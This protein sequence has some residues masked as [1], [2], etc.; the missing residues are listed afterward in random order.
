MSDDGE[1][2]EDGTEDVKSESDEDGGLTPSTPEIAARDPEWPVTGSGLLAETPY[3]TVG[4]DDVRR[5]DGEA[6]Y[7]W[8][9][10]GDAVVVVAHDRET[11]ELLMVEQYRPKLRGR[12]C[13]LPGG[14]IDADESPREAARRELREET[15]YRAGRLD[16]LGAYHPSSY[17][18]MTRHVWYA[19]DLSAGEPD[20]DDGERL[21]VTRRDPA[22]ALRECRESVATGWTITP[23]LWA[24]NGGYL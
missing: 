5:P 24:T 20:R 18:R 15:G 23:L 17:T 9:D 6:R 1:G 14:G 8:I 21:S 4:Y 2:S 19:T 11:D 16:R 12:F 22:A 13:E 3:F 10:P 7:Y